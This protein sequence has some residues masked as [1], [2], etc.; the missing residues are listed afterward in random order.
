MPASGFSS[1]V[2]IEGA[3]GSGKTT[4]LRGFAH[5]YACDVIEVGVLVRALAWRVAASGIT[6]PDAVSELTRLERRGVFRWQVCD[7]PG[8][9]AI[10]VALEGQRLSVESLGPRIGANVAAVSRSEIGMEWVHALVREHVRGRSAGISGRDVATRT[11]PG[12]P[13]VIRLTAEGSVRRRRKLGQLLAAGLPA[14]WSDDE[15]L[16]PPSP[17]EAVEIDTNRLDADEVL[18]RAGRLVEQQLGW[19]QSAES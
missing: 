6:I 15:A 3:S 1:V 12:V 2:A 5:R 19:Q 17:P 14:S 9:A 7:E 10:E 13:L 18:D 8:L 4:L 16:L 11:V